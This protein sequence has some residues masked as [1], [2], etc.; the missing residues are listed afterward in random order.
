MKQ[1]EIPPEL[2]HLKLLQRVHA[3]FRAVYTFVAWFVLGIGID[4]N[5][6]FG[7]VFLFVSP[8]LMD[9]FKSLFF[10]NGTILQ[11][12]FVICL[13][14]CVASVLGLFGVLIVDASYCVTTADNFIG[15]QLPPI[16]V[17]SIWMFLSSIF[18]LTVIDVFDSPRREV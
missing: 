3:I 2:R 1:K 8:V 18:A 9:V 17:Q 15:F 7:S 14:W 12:E 11:T 6:F 4:S 10:A 13:F 5:A 16:S